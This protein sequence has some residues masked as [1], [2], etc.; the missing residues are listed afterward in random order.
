MKE[1]KR[2]KWLWC[3]HLACNPPLLREGPS[4]LHHGP[5]GRTSKGGRGRW[6]EEKE[7]GEPAWRD[8]VNDSE[9]EEKKAAESGGEERTLRRQKSLSKMF[10]FRDVRSQKSHAKD[11]QCSFYSVHTADV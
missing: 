5:L 7:G 3:V 8:R 11:L 2:K 1:K 6:G 4:L 9:E 10:A